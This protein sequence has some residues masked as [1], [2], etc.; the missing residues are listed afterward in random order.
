MLWRKIESDINKWLENGK[1][2]LLITGARQAGKTFVIEKCLSASSCDYVSFNL[3]ERPD[4]IRVLENCMDRNTESFVSR[5]S[6]L[7]GREQK[8]GKTIIFF[9]EIQQCIEILTAIKFLVEDGSY[10]YILS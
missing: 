5:I 3:L 1:G 4:V 6:L 7:A 8:K 2:A 9:D 10:R